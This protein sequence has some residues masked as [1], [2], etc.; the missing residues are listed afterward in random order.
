MT[1]ILI[2]KTGS[3]F[4][5][6]AAEYGDF[7]AF[8]LRAMTRDGVR[9]TVCD[10]AAGEPLSG[11]Q[12]ADG[13]VITGSPAMVTDREPWSEATAA[14]LT[15]WVDAGKP[16]L[17]I[18]YGHQ[19]LAHALGGTVAN[20]PD[21]R[22]MGTLEVALTENAADDPLFAGMPPSFP[23]HLTHRQSVG[24][25]PPNAVLLARSAVEP[26][27]AF[28]AGRCTW[29][30]QFHPEFDQQIMRA[31]IDLQESAL[32]AEGRQPELMRA[33]LTE[34]RAATGLLA[35]FVDLVRQ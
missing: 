26:H 4:P 31:Y 34:T 24:T 2:L 9:F 32:L 22:E 1:N 12:N 28:R 30:V 13:L 33:Q 18:C 25:L 17:G 23:A 6:I 19:L 11:Y 27:Q 15:G 3:T 16:T 29:G 14:W 8:F 35:R 21:G 5:A 20:H 7:D 10:V